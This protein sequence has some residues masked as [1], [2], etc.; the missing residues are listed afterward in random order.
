MRLGEP[1]PDLGRVEGGQPVLR[2]VF[3]FIS[4]F[5]FLS[6]LSL[7]L[8]AQVLSFACSSPVGG[9]LFGVSGILL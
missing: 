7:V 1:S 5:L 4:S 2:A 3:Y 9:T 6:F 8:G